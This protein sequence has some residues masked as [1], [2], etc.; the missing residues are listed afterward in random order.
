MGD[1]SKMSDAAKI[2]FLMAALLDAAAVMRA[3][4]LHN[5]ARRYEGY[6]R[7]MRGEV[8]QEVK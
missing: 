3:H 8:E 4:D 5:A 2:A 7:E 1:L 6:V